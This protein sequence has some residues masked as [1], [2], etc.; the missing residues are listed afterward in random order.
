MKIKSL[1]VFALLTAAVAGGCATDEGTEVEHDVSCEGASSGLGELSCR[2]NKPVDATGLAFD[3]LS[4]PVLA[5]QMTQEEAAKASR[6]YSGACTG[7]WY[8]CS[9]VAAEGW[10]Y[11]S[12]GSSHYV[13]M[14]FDGAYGN[15]IGYGIGYCWF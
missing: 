13:F 14:T 7:I 15:L 6:T 1:L 8:G 11:E 12:C 5:K 4:T 9:R 3:Q 10:T 2:Q